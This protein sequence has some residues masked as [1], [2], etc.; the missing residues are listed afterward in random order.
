MN[1][2]KNNFGQK[3]FLPVNGPCKAIAR[4]FDGDGDLDIASISYFPDYDHH[5]E[6]SFIFWENTGNLSFKPS[7][8]NNASMGR[9]LTMEAGDIDHDGDIDLVLGNAKFPLGH[10]PDSLMKNWNKYSP[11]LVILKNQTKGF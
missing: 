5:P 10:I 7:S 9:W 6:E 11:S 2:G 4:D 3:V 1:D 8:F